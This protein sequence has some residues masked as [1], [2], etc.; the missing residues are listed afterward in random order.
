[1]TQLVGHVN[2]WVKVS[3][4]NGVELEQIILSIQNMYKIN[5]GILKR[6]SVQQIRELD[7]DAKHLKTTLD[8]E[9]FRLKEEPKPRA[10]TCKWCFC[11]L[12]YSITMFKIV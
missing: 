11:L 3:M 4:V 6:K 9:E 2:E 12:L 7:H 5:Q 10:M 1:M 8:I